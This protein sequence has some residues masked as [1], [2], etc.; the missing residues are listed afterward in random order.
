MSQND[1]RSSLDYEQETAFRARRQKLEQTH[2]KYLAAHPELHYMLHDLTQELLIH[3]PED[4]LLFIQNRIKAMSDRGREKT[5][6]AAKS[7]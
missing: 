2:E 7:K 4:P 6:E 5:V 3:K 1:L